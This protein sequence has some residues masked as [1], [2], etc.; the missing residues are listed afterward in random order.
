MINRDESVA[1][2]RMTE[3]CVCVC[4]RGRCRER[5][6]CLC[7]SLICWFICLRDEKRGRPTLL[8]SVRRVLFYC[9]DKRHHTSMESVTVARARYA[10][11][12]IFPSAAC[13]VM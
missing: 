2:S 4:V 11:T 13:I 5:V 6:T 10:Y 3:V 7:C 12:R 1:S 8:G 9:L